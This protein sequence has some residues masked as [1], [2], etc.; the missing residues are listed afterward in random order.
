MDMEF[1]FHQLQAG[2][3]YVD[4]ILQPSFTWGAA[5]ESV[6][7]GERLRTVENGYGWVRCNSGGISAVVSPYGRYVLESALL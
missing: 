2:Q 3:G 4:L 1:P 7:E 6:F 5:G